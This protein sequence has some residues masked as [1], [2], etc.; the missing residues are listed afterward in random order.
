MRGTLKRGPKIS[1]WDDASGRGRPLA[2]RVMRVR[3]VSAALVGVLLLLSEGRQD[4]VTLSAHAAVTP[5]TRC[6]NEL[7]IIYTTPPRES[8]S[9][10][11]GR[12]SVAIGQI[13]DQNKR[14]VEILVVGSP[15]FDVSN[16]EFD[17]GRVLIFERVKGG[18]N[19]AFR[20]VATFV[21]TGA[22]DTLGFSVAID[23]VRIVA[24]AP[25]FTDTGIGG[26]VLV[27]ERD[28]NG[29]WREIARLHPFNPQQES[30]F[31]HSVA[32]DGDDLMVG[33]P[34]WATNGPKAGAAHLFRFEAQTIV[35]ILTLLPPSTAV[36]F[37]FGYAV[38]LRDG[39]AAVGEPGASFQSGRVHIFQEVLGWAHAQTLAS[40]SVGVGEV[41]HEHFGAV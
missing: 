12:Q 35:E 7:E 23:G 11:L 13:M 39:V 4:T 32:L 10:A 16:E 24:G 9:F 26:Y 15:V 40:P 18:G 1:S 27:V 38:A 36:Q 22:G 3:L 41:P 20:Q 30:R 25:Q 17:V 29:T 28:A 21:G 5:V 34:H 14:V 37:N 33:S 31:G 6:T 2:E 8:E 19:D